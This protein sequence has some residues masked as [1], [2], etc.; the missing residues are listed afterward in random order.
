MNLL[1]FD[2]LNA[3]ITTYHLYNQKMTIVFADYHNFKSDLKWIKHWKGS[4]CW[5]I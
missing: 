2:V 1:N 5:S 4:L 3:D